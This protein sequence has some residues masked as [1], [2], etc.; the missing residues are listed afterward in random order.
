MEDL[1]P[2]AYILGIRV[3][4]DRPNRTL[5]LVQDGY[6]ERILERFGM[7]ECAPAPTPVAV[8]VELQK[9]P[10]PEDVPHSQW[11]KESCP[12]RQA[13]G[14]LMYAMVSTRPDIATAVGMLSRYLDC[15]QWHHWVAAKRVFRYLRG[16]T[17]YGLQL[18][19]GGMQLSAWSDADWAGD[20]DT[21]RS[22]SGYVLQL[23]GSVVS[24]SSKRQEIVALSTT[25][26]EYIALTRAAQ[27]VLWVG[28]VLAEL[29]YDPETVPV[30]VKGDN[31]G[32]LGLA[33]NPEF[34]PRTK[35]IAVRYHWIR[36]LV[37]AGLVQV[38]YVQ[39][40]MMLADMMTK[41]LDRVKFEQA[42]SR[43]GMVQVQVPK[44]PVGNA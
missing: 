38:E 14:S 24:W 27:E 40:A 15:P 37:K 22:T 7:G 19:K 9:V 43:L 29:G 18:G 16:T 25:E 35:H 8:G 17:K 32:A 34:H 20:V 31:Q 2:Q 30:V 42:R 39:S 21:R 12:Y 23:G 33:K 5:Y 11:M 4:R 10:L 41:P 3:V 44:N 28:G 13:V 1:G 26:S 36:D 6:V